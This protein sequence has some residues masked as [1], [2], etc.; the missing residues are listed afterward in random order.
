MHSEKT[1]NTRL[2][3]LLPS[4]SLT[5]LRLSTPAY[6]YPA[7]HHWSPLLSTTPHSLAPHFQQ[8]Q[9]LPPAPTLAAS[10]AALQTPSSAHLCRALPSKQALPLMQALPSTHVLSS[11]QA[12]PPTQAMS[13]REASL[14]DVVFHHL[15]HDMHHALAPRHVGALKHL[16]HLLSTGTRGQQG[17]PSMASS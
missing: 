5:S 13:S 10:S 1:L 6:D 12:L 17:V 3:T 4:L 9:L 15:V 14:V 7:E 16:L 11:M 2:C 8:K